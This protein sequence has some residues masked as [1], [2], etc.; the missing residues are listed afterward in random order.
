MTAPTRV[1]PESLLVSGASGS[2]GAALVEEALSAGTRVVAT[3]SSETG[4]AR[5]DTL[6]AITGGDLTVVDVDLSRPQELDP[7]LADLRSR[8][9]PPHAFVALSSGASGGP[10]EEKSYEE[11]AGLL[12]TKV[13]SAGLIASA[14]GERLALSGWGRIV[15]VTGITGRE[16]IDGYAVGAAANAAMRTLTKSLSRRWAEAGVTVNAVCPGPVE[17]D[18]LRA[19]APVLDQAGEKEVSLGRTHPLGR[20]VTAAEVVAV[21]RFLLGPSSSGVNGAEVVVDGGFGRAV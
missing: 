12:H 19:L 2:I 1:W 15:L 14:L 21:V 4:R 7:L 10:L 6:G 13:W 20:L 8:P 5:L 16:P 3:T 11:L 9:D 18:R 17:S